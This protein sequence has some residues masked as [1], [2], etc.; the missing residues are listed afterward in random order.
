MNVQSFTS[1]WIFENER[2]S[3]TMKGAEKK[4]VL[5]RLVFST[6]SNKILI[7]KR[8]KSPLFFVPYK[9]WGARGSE[10]RGDVP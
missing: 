3:M 5:S 10:H 6:G 7:K 9:D 8:E 4:S 1:E 2:K